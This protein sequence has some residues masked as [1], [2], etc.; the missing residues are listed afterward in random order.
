MYRANDRPPGVCPS[1]QRGLVRVQHAGHWFERCPGCNGIWLDEVTLTAMWREMSAAAPPLSLDDR[2]SEGAPR[3]CPTCGDP[4]A[5]VS[6]H[7]IP[8]D[9]CVVD[10]VWFDFPELEMALARAALPEDDWQWRFARRLQ[11]LR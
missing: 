10:G 9:R 8:V 6:L 2:E 3:A 5:T 4:M 1:C 11:T 7:S